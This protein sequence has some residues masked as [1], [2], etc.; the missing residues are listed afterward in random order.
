MST[1]AQVPRR[2]SFG[3]SVP[4]DTLDEVSWR[5]VDDDRA[6]CELERLLNQCPAIC[7]KNLPQLQSVTMK[8]SCQTVTIIML[9][10]WHMLS[11]AY[12]VTSILLA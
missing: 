11:E 6:A 10:R 1:Y 5:L 4:L 2:P 7:N 3:G 8:H 9:M 12:I